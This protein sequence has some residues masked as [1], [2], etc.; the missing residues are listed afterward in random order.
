MRSVG[1]TAAAEPLLDPA[2]GGWA[3]VPVEVVDLSSTP[4][5]SQP[6]GFVRSHDPARI[7]RVRRIEVRTTHTAS[8]ILFHLAWADDACNTAVTDND[9]FPDGCGILFP[10]RPGDAPIQEMGAPGK[11][12]NAWFWRADFRDAARN[13][14]AE[15]LGTTRATARSAVVARARWDDGG[16][17]LV[18]ARALVVPEQETETVQLAVGVPTQIGFAVWEGSNGERGGLKSFSREWRSFELA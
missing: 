17:R 11:A 15:G 4:L 9:T 2:A 7:G 18:L 8:T 16:W 10:L 13:V 12:V 14:V 5:A 3:A 6:S 1:T